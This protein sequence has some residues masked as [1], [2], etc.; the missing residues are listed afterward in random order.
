MFLGHN[1]GLVVPRSQDVVSFAVEKAKENGS[2]STYANT[3][4]TGF[5]IENGRVTGVKTDKG[6]IKTEK[7][8]IT[9]GIWG[10]LLG[11][12]AGVPV[13]LSPVEHPLLFFGPFFVIKVI[14][15]MSEIQAGFMEECLNGVF[16][17]IKNLG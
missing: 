15:L 3:P 2:L 7:V 17:K 11:E 16:M 14:L 6:T 5:E 8:V 12:M 1:A 10:P 9:S 13:P 4:A